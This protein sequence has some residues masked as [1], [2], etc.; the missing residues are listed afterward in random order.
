MEIQQS[1]INL[2]EKWSGEKVVDFI[3]LPESTSARKYYRI[4]SGNKRAIGAFN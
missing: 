2:F 3:P 1:L 4:G